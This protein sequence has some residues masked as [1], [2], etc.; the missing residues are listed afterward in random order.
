M[1][2]VSAEGKYDIAS[3]V[4]NGAY[5]KYVDSGIS[6]TDGWVT[7]TYA[8]DTSDNYPEK[9]QSVFGVQTDI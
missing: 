7:A 1:L 4:N 6:N 3:V 8:V 5:I 2:A 9:Q